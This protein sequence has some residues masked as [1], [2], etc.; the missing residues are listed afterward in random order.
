MDLAAHGV[1]L[2][3]ARK[4]QLGLV[5]VIYV[6]YLAQISSLLVLADG[7]LDLLSQHNLTGIP[8]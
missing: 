7:A 1:H 4:G 5:C 8:D 3:F 2:N 6:I